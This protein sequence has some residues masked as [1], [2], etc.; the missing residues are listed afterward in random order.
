MRLFLSAGLIA[1]ALLTTSAFANDKKPVDPDKKVCRRDYGTTGSILP[2]SVCHTVAD[3]KAIDEANR[4][5]AE[6]IQ[7][8]RNNQSGSN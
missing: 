8:N 5:N 2:K 1:T 3:W 4:G 7:R 6:Q